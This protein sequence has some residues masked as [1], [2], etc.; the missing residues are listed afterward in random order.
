LLKQF[1][2]GPVPREAIDFFKAKGLRPAFSYLDVWQQE[3]DT[4]FTVARLLEKDLLRDVQ[5]SLTQ[6]LD[7]GTPFEQWS[8]EIEGT[9][10]QSGWIN[11]RPGVAVPQRLQV[12]YNTN[13]RMARAVG[14][15]E[16]VERTKRALPYMSFEL[17]PSRVHRDQHVDWEGTILPVDDP[18]WDTHS[19]PLGYG[20][21]CWRRQLTRGEAEERGVSE[22]PEEDLVDYEDPKTGETR[23][24]DRNV[25]PSF[26]YPRT[27]AARTQALEAQLEEP[28]NEDQEGNEL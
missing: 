6:A 2:A 22:R 28:E 18:W 26:A 17:G 20:C 25:D 9:F 27:Q 8:Q 10:E 12:I 21:K 16:R 13:M 14:Q 5:T 7:E 24:V 15:A 4:A 19:P 23:Q 1:Q 11:E 3:H